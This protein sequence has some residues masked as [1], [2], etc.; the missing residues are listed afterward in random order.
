MV[1]A[2]PTANLVLRVLALILIVAGIVIGLTA[3]WAQGLAAVVIGL[4]LLIVD[5]ATRRRR[6]GGAART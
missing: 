6:D 5:E 1:Q 4:A 2:H 3:G